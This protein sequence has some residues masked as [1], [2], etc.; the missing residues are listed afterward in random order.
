[1]SAAQTA[2]HLARAEA[3]GAGPFAELQAEIDADKL[4]SHA[5]GAAAV[6]VGRVT[7]LE[8]VGPAVMSEHDRDLWKATIEVHAVQSGRLRAGT[9]IEVLYANSLDVQWHQVPKPKASQEALF[10]LH[11]PDRA[12]RALGKYQ[13]Q[14]PEDLQPSQHLD[15]IA[16]GS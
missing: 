2:P 15:V 1:V 3:S 13:I 11:A 5:T 12:D 14:H 16:N 4:R 8:K 9:E 10:L 6:V 7:K